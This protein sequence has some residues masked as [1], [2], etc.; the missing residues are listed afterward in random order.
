MNQTRLRKIGLGLVAVAALAA[1]VV[2]KNKWEALMMEMSSNH[3][4]T[5]KRDRNGPLV[6]TGTKP[7][8]QSY[9]PAP[10]GPA[11]LP[12]LGRSADSGKS[13][14]TNPTLEQTLGSGIRIHWPRDFSVSTI[15]LEASTSLRDGGRPF[16]VGTVEGNGT[17]I[18]AA[19]PGTHRLSLTR[20]SGFFF[21]D[22]TVN[23]PAGRVVDF[24]PEVGNIRVYWPGR[25]DTYITVLEGTVPEA[26]GGIPCSGDYVQANSIV[27]L[28]SPT[29][30]HLIEIGLHGVTF[31]GIVSVPTAG[32]VDFRFAVGQV[33]LQIRSGCRP[34]WGP[35]LFGF[36]IGDDGRSPAIDYPPGNYSWDPASERLVCRGEQYQ[37]PIG[38]VR[39]SVKDGQ[40]T[41][42]L[43]PRE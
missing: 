17:L 30:T 1:I 21:A 34:V 43:I 14:F 25:E 28:P 16:S 24:T 26:E 22:F 5:W 11:S 35:S 42:V 18:L 3:W 19:L 13:S 20:P 37:V 41:T 8:D 9:K 4:V 40:K 15:V 10:E 36:P 6:A 39:F 33:A 27:S 31:K 12:Q 32:T 7:P 38:V 2:P 23:V 29:G